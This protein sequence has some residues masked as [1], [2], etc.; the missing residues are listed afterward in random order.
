M[1]GTENPL[2]PR[3]TRARKSAAPEKEKTP[4]FSVLLPAVPVVN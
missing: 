1:D 2:L 3:V 4:A